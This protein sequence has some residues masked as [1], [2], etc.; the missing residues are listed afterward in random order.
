[1]SRR[2]LNE[3]KREWEQGKESSITMDSIQSR[4]QDNISRGMAK[5]HALAEEPEDNPTPQ[6]N[7]AKLVTHRGKPLTS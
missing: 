7:R 6:K 1:M 2:E 4:M 3:A 5:L